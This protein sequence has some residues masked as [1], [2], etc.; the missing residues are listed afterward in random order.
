MH[1]AWLGFIRAFIGKLKFAY[2]AHQ[3]KRHRQG[4][5][6]VADL[7]K[8]QPH[9]RQI[10]SPDLSGALLPNVVQ[11]LHTG[12]GLPQEQGHQSHIQTH[13]NFAGNQ[14]AVLHQRR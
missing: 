2:A 9:C 13:V 10:C 12:E 4:L 3:S 7:G 14:I 1:W 8:G 6:E 11:D 5:R